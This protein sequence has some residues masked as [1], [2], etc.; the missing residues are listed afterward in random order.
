M[1]TGTFRLELQNT[2]GTGFSDSY[3]QRYDISVTPDALTEIE[4]MLGK[5]DLAFGMHVSAEAEFALSAEPMHQPATEE[6]GTEA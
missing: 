6:E 4:E 1:T 3:F 2:A 5:E